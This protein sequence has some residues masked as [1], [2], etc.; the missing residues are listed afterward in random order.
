MQSPSFI[1]EQKYLAH[2]QKYKSGY[3]DGKELSGLNELLAE[4]IV[5]Q[6]FALITRINNYKVYTHTVFNRYNDALTDL[7][8]SFRFFEEV[9]PENPN[10]NIVKIDLFISAGTLYISLHEYTEAITYFEQAAVTAVEINDEQEIIY[11]KNGLSQCYWAEEMFEEMLAIN[12][13]LLDFC[14]N[15]DPNADDYYYHIAYC[16]ANMGVA[17]GDLG[18]NDLERQTMEAVE[19]ILQEHRDVNLYINNAN[20]L[21]DAY[22]KSLDIESAKPLMERTTSYLPD[23]LPLE[24]KAI[25][26]LMKGNFCFLTQAYENAMEHY[27]NVIDY[28]TAGRLTKYADIALN[29]L[30]ES[31]IELERFDTSKKYL[32]LYKKTLK[33][34]Y[35]ISRGEA[36]ARQEA[37]F[38][39]KVLQEE[40]RHNKELFEREKIAKEKIEQ[41][42]QRVQLLNQE[43]EAFTRMVAH[44]LKS[45]LRSINGF[46][47]ILKRRMGAKLSSEETE[48][49]ELVVSS[50]TQMDRLLYKLLEYARLDNSTINFSPV[51]L[52]DLMEEVS[53]VLHHEI[54]SSNT[55]III[56][57]SLP[58]IQ[59]E[60]NYLL[61]LFQNLVSNAMKFIPKE[62]KPRILI[63]SIVK[64]NSTIIDI[65]DNGIGISK[66]KWGNV[67]ETFTRLNS[68]AEYKGTG[69]GLAT[70]KKVMDLHESTIKVNTSTEAGTTFRL[71][72]A[73]ASIEEALPELIQ[74]K[75][76]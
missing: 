55:E 18:K 24:L 33:E 4:A 42:K 6:D 27:Q 20:N 74:A 63:K 49:I 59:G 41:E 9:K 66:D 34:H 28:E 15:R 68:Q 43:L 30:L 47:S 19:L 39:F 52:G 13:E 75:T 60:P 48:L 35:K 56:A 17:Y 25:Y 64:E 16:K 36:M 70:C 51:N 14:T 21:M 69:L 10:Y 54:T 31:C 23:E 62:R 5:L 45:P 8:D 71:E 12:Q 50:T 65:S 1:L 61:I 44:D 58:T 46:M 32:K 3:S 40:S 22:N 67:F 72:F 7:K 57:S 76:L 11:A 38:K 53:R 73:N 2:R 37:L 29:K 26:E